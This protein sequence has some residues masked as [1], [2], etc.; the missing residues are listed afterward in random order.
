[1]KE[2]RSVASLRRAA[3]RSTHTRATLE[4]TRRESGAVPGASDWSASRDLLGKLETSGPS[5]STTNTHTGCD[6]AGPR[7]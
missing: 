1:M 6:D 2:E 7:S 5:H 3:T 4:L